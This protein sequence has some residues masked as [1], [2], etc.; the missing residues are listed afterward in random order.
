[1]HADDSPQ[2]TL[3]ERFHAAMLHLYYTCAARLKPPYFAARFLAL[4]H[5]C[6][7]KQAADQL[8]AGAAPSA[9]FI[10]LALRGAEHLPLS[11][12]Y[13]VLQSP[14]CA[15]F[16]TE[17]RAIARERLL[18]AGCTPPEEDRDID[19]SRDQAHATTVDD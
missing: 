19:T 14:W 8:L 3:E 11:V 1:M 13:L 2:W 4:V 12:E 10:E 18:Q 6:G 16:S 9:G 17:Q 7:G 15:L 5:E